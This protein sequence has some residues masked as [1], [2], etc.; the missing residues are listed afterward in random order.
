M[1]DSPVFTSPEPFEAERINALAIY[2]SDGRFGEQFD[3]FLH[4]HLCLPR[5]DRLA[6]PGGPACLAGH[7]TSENELIGIKSQIRFLIE[8]HN[9]NTIVLIQHHNCAFYAHA[10]PGKQFEQIKPAQDLD[11]GA[12]A[13]ELRKMRPSLRVLTIFARLVG[14]RVQFE[15][16]HP[17]AVS[18][19]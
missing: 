18:T 9:L 6:V 11:L 5:Y 14:D 7:Y 17:E 12:A 4:H 13:A 19:N 2:C 15:E 1:P 3:D 8:A 16:V 10:M